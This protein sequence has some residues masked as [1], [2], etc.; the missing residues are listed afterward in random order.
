M[1]IIVTKVPIRMI[2]FPFTIEKFLFLKKLIKLNIISK[3][4]QNLRLLAGD[5]LTLRI[6]SPLRRNSCAKEPQTSP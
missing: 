6:P 2:S 1:Q 3:Q 4:C 5:T